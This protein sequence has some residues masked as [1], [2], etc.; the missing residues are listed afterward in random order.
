MLKS[1]LQRELSHLS[2]LL[3]Q[4]RRAQDYN[5]LMAYLKGLTPSRLD[6]ELRYMQV[7]PPPPALPPREVTS[8]EPGTALSDAHQLHFSL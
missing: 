5:R 3:Q 6:S 8:L 1:G 4:G 2:R 7:R